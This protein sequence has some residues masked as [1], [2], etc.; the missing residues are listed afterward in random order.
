MPI[1]AMV[2]I[3]T[4]DTEPTALV[5]SVGAVKFDPYTNETPFEKIVWYPAL[6]EQLTLGRTIS[7]STLEWWSKQNPEILE[8]ALTDEDR[9]TLNDFFKSFNRYLVG[10]DKIWCQGPQFD[11]VILEDLYRKASHHVSWQ[12][13]QIADSRTLFNI[14]PR[15]PR[16]DIQQDLHDAGADAYYQAVAVQ[17][18]FE[19]FGVVPR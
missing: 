3:E 11:M 13:W 7:D 4:L 2:D 9:I 8:R 19:H 17:K 1:S 16:K 15:D 10:M 18:T 6:E 5:L 14:M 12:F